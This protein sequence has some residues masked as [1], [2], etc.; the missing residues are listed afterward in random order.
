MNS[1]SISRCRY[2]NVGTMFGI[3]FLILPALSFTTPAY[4]AGGVGHYYIARAAVEQ[5]MQ[6]S[7]LPQQFKEALKDPSCRNSFCNG[8]IAPDLAC[9][10]D[11]AHHGRTTKIFTKLLDNAETAL[12]QA[13]SLPDGNPSKPGKVKEAMKGVCFSIGWLSHCATDIAIHPKV[14]AR[15]GDAY[16]FCNTGKKGVHTADE[17]QFSRYLADTYKKPDWKIAFDIP[18]QLVSKSSNV[19]EQKLQSS[20]KVMRMKLIAELAAMQKVTLPKSDLQKQWQALAGKSIQDTVRFASS[21]GLFQDY[22]LDY[23]PIVTDDF[24]ELRKECIEINDGKVPEQWGR[25]NLNWWGIVKSMNPSA[26][27]QKLIELIKGQQPVDTRQIIITPGGSISADYYVNGIKLVPYQGNVMKM[28]ADGVLKVQVSA[29]TGKKWRCDKKSEYTG[30]SV[31]IL[32]QDPYALHYRSTFRNKPYEY[33][34]SLISEKYTWKP[35]YTWN[36]RYGAGTG[37]SYSSGIHPK[38]KDDC[39]E[40]KLPKID[41]I[42]G[43]KEYLNLFVTAD[44]DWN[45]YTSEEGPKTVSEQNIALGLKV[46]IAAE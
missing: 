15:C 37:K 1:T 14:N 4:S 13:Q 22:D 39:F 27:H 10:V 17:I 40:W 29:N 41:K 32:K 42:Q 46:E 35:S 3:A 20:V 45:Y 23:G 7:S 8:A 25:E 19:T 34:L 12:Q 6:S 44:L 9:I 5:I 30:S 24:R 28:P 36:T 33:D 26:R 11:Q 21:P 31:Q 16:E 38:V 2:N 18:Y 43:G